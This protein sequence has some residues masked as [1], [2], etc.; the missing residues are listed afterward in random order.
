MWLA[1]NDRKD[2]ALWL[3]SFLCV[4]FCGVEI[5]ILCAVLSSLFIV[6]VEQAR[7]RLLLP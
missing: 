6:F 7:E 3:A 2:L 4:L 5:G 1:K